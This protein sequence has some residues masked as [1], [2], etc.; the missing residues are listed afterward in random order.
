MLTPAQV[1]AF[2]EDGYVCID[3]LEHPEGLTE[4]ELLAAERTFDRLVAQQG[5]RGRTYRLG[6]DAGF[7]DLISHPF[8][9]KI[10]QQ[11]IRAKDVRLIELGPHHRPP[12]GEPHWTPEQSAAA[13]ARAAHIDLQITTSDF[14][15][16][17]R[18]DL[19]ALWFWVNDVPEDR[20]AM[21]ILPGSHKP[22][23][24][25]WEQT[26]TA[27]HK[28]WLPRVHGLKPHPSEKDVAYPE[29]IPEP[30]GW[31][32]TQCEPTAVAVR[33]GTAQIFT[34]SM[35]HAGWH[36]STDT[37][38]KGFIIGW[39]AAELPVGFVRARRDGLFSLFPPLR[40]AIARRHPGRE[41][42]VPEAAEHIH[43][44]SEYDPSWPETWLEGC[45]RADHR[46]RL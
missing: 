19:L 25:H 40:A 16:S 8:F 34:Q 42:I 35:L 5:K 6:Q 38:R 23:Q 4:A 10:A 2:E 7:L 15:A 45:T 41:H 26:L 17:P 32:Y 18:R 11:V 29:H 14:R 1:T 24:E 36:N 43:F 28:A 31:R 46:P 20:A 9:E 13:W 30:E 12:T 37:S 22:I 39:A 3:A 21:R 44:V 33:R 27:E